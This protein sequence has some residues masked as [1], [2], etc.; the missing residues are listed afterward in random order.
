MKPSAARSNPEHRVL[1]GHEPQAE[2]IAVVG[3]ERAH[4]H[5]RAQHPERLLAAVLAHQAGGDRGIDA[6]PSEQGGERVAAREPVFVPENVRLVGGQLKG[7]DDERLDD[8]GALDRCGRGLR[9]GAEGGHHAEQREA[10]EQ[11]RGPAPAPC[12]P[13]RVVR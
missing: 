5:A 4:G 13:R 7:R 10:G 9:S 3:G 1:S 8:Q 12:A 11:N 6:E 2:Q